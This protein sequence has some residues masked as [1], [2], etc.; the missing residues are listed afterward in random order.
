MKRIVASI[1]KTVC[2]LSTIIFIASMAMTSPTEVTGDSAT[3]L[4]KSNVIVVSFITSVVT[5][6]I[7]VFTGIM[8]NK[9]ENGG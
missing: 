9:N 2:V 3:A 8:F 4:A 7:C 6:I 1:V 5:S